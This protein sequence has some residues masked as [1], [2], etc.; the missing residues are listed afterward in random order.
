MFDWK[1]FI[2]VFINISGKIPITIALTI[3]SFLFGLI[4]G[5][6][7]ALVKI[8]KIK[9]IL[10][11]VKAMISFLRGTPVI[12][13]LYLV[14][15]FLPAVYD[16]FAQKMGWSFTSDKIPIFLLVLIA[17]GLNLSAY[18]AETIRSGV[19]SVSEGEIEAAVSLGM[20]GGM[21]F[22][23]IIFPEAMRICIPNFSTILINSLYGT[24]LAFYVTLVELTGQ[25][26]ILAQDNWKYLETFL[27]AG[28]IYWAL[29]ILIETATHFIEKFL[30]K[31]GKATA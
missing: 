10:P 28:L 11:L 24:S 8:Y 25:A 26:N 23:R 17:L 7:L 9:I 3:S 15:Y 22:K 30:N 6:L 13:Q 20:T 16:G 5:F 1:Y 29:T 31:S 27:G 4:I 18:L 12:L 14:Y 2:E 21:V 19:E